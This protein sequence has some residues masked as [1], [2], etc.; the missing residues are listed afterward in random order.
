M[1]IEKKKKQRQIFGVILGKKAASDSADVESE[2]KVA[3][4]MV[5]G[6][7]D[8]AGLDSADAEGLSIAIMMTLTPFF[9]S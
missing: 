6:R 2:G 9:G 4:E 7:G 1:K 3:R 5:T 8:V